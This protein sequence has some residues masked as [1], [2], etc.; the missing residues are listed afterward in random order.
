[1]IVPVKKVSL[2]TITDNES[3]MLEGLGKLGVVQLRKLD[4]AEFIG[5]EKVIIE[6]AREYE[7][8]KERFQILYGK[9]GNIK[10]AVAY[11]FRCDI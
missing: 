4:E 6:E 7:N 3:S 11:C 1:M 5:F 10:R 8:L 9:F 2:I